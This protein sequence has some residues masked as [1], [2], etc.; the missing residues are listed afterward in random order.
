M[1]LPVRI[2]VCIPTYNGAAFVAQAISSVLAQSFADFE[3][4]VVD[5]RSTDATLEIV[6]SFTDPRLR[7]Y[8]NDVQLGIPRNWNRCL[9]LARGEYLCLFHQDD[10]MLPENLERKVGVLASDPTIGFVHSAV[11]VVLEDSA[12]T[13]IADWMER[14]T[15]D[16]AV[17]GACYFR[18]LLF[19]GNP[20]C[21]PTVV[22]RRRSLLELGGF[23]E[24]LG[25]ACDYE[26]WMK[27]CVQSGVA[28]LAQTLIRYRWHDQ[29][30]SHAYRFEQG[31]EECLIAG[32]RALQYY[33][34]RTGQPGEE[35]ILQNALESVAR[36]RKWAAEL[37]RG[38]AWLEE[39]RASW[40][41]VAE[42]RE[43]MF[44]EQQA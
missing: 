32:R 23:D 37:E 5:D 42:E 11:E 2:S 10:V 35:E 15:E 3:L 25:F 16:F 33:L 20:I 13:A 22:T 1:D 27:L 30:A 6:R 39:Q 4:L 24:E 41:H 17:D 40:Q 14:A 9:S 21:A 43:K 44:R 34:Q 7:V 8:Q 12:P 36:L 31:A 38:R 26:M 28:F 29:N 19:A 18:K